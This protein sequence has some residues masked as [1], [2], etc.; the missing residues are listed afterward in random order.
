MRTSLNPI[1]VI[2]VFKKPYNTDYEDST[3]DFKIIWVKKV[4]F[5]QMTFCVQI[6]TAMQIVIPNWFINQSQTFLVQI[7]VNCSFDR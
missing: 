5:L 2:K 3:F 7:F 4:Q 6:K 1:S